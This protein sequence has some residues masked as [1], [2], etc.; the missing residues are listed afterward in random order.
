ML[1]SPDG[2]EWLDGHR[3]DGRARIYVASH[4]IPFDFTNASISVVIY[5]ATNDIMATVWYS[6]GLGK[7][8]LA[9]YFDR[10]GIA[11]SNY[12]GISVY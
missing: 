9:V 7:Q 8:C 6:S 12:L 3:F 11:V 10:K 5:N 1:Q 2:R 4:D